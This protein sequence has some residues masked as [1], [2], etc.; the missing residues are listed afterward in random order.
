MDAKRVLRRASSARVLCLLGLALSLPPPWPA[1][2]DL[3]TQLTFDGTLEDSGPGGNDGTFFGAGGPV[4]VLGADGTAGGALSLDGADDFVRLTN[5]TALPIHQNPQFSLAVWVQGLGTQNDRRVF[6]E[7]SSTNATPLWTLGTQSQGTASTLDSYVRSSAGTP[8]NHDQSVGA[9][10]DGIWHHLAWVDNN[11]DVT[12]YIDGVVDAANFD[13]PRPPATGFDT[14]TI[15]SVVRDSH[16]TPQCC[17]YAGAVDDLRL[18]DHVLSQVEIEAI[19]SGEGECPG[20]GSPDFA[21]TRLGSVA[22]EGPIDGEPG[23]PG[24]YRFTALG[25]V[26]DTGDTILYAFEA[27]DGEGTVLARELLE[28]DSAEFTL[29]EGEWTVTARVDDA[30]LCD[31]AAGTATRSLA[32]AVTCPAA[33]DTTVAA[34]IIEGPN[35]TDGGGA[36]VNPP[37]TYRA[38]AV[39]PVDE[40]GGAVTLTFTAENGI[41]PPLVA[42]PIAGANSALF[43]LHPGEWTVSVTAD[44]NDQCDDTSPGATRSSAITVSAVSDQLVSRWRLDGNFLDS[45]P[46]GNDGVLVDPDGFGATFVDGFDANPAGAVLLDGVNDHVLAGHDAHLP[47]RANRAYSVALWVRGLTGQVD[48]RVFSESYSRAASDPPAAQDIDPLFNIGTH[49]TGADGSVDIYIRDDRGVVLVPHLRTAR[50]AFDGSWHHV[51]WVA[52]DGRGAVYIDAVRDQTSFNHQH[53]QLTLDTTSLG[54]V[55]RAESSFWFDGDLDDVRVYNYALS[56]AE[57]EAL[58]PEPLGC[59]DSGDPDFRDTICDTLEVEGPEGGGSNLTGVYTLTALDADDLSG[60]PVIYTFTATHPDGDHLQAGPQTVNTASIRIKKEGTWTFSVVVDDDLACRDRAAGATCTQVRE[61]SAPLRRLITRYRFDGNLLDSGAAGNHG[62]F[63]NA[64]AP[65]FVPDPEG[66]A[67]SALALDGMNDWVDPQIAGGLPVFADPSVIGYTVALWVRGMPQPDMRV[68]SEESSTDNTPLFTLGTA[69]GGVSGAFNVFIRPGPGHR[70]STGVAFDG[71]WHHVAWVDA[72]GEAV[73]YID[74][75]PD[76]ADFRYTKP[77][78][79]LDRATVGAVVRPARV[80]PECCLFT[81]ELDD[82]RVYNYAL[83]PEEVAIL[84]SGGEDTDLDAVADGLDNCPE[85][86]N[87]EQT[88]TDLDLAGDACDP[89][90]DGDGVADGVD[91]CP[92]VSNSAQTDSDGDGLGDACDAPSGVGPFKRGDCNQDGSNTGQVTDGVFLLNYLFQGGTVP[93]C[94]AACD[95]NGDGGVPGSPTDAVAYFNFNFQGGTPLADPLRECARSTR[96][97]DLRVGCLEP[98]ACMPP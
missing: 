33:G 55:A 74:G 82:V 65:V 28:D 22:A 30:P 89:D 86:P 94:L 64:Q 44:D 19:L 63:S 8:N 26:D 40:S 23:E 77:D 87:P 21:D 70:P 38:T 14:T 67:G 18:Y 5:A 79:P 32:V 92:L 20:V 52:E 90:D 81:G 50:M 84:A 73:L 60:D 68:Y 25:A 2:A 46:A 59:P 7:S 1:R 76:A 24:V 62:T 35:A 4:Y 43:T 42:G 49:S 80:P 37:G 83:S 39:A 47:I 93:P 29:G 45:Q 53:G 56:S 27:S 15:G 88:D 36:G 31:D 66:N 72:C 78:L 41:D 34:L 3:V 91:N 71:T 9:A 13:Y 17:F 85:V 16:T 54:A 11:G 58:V 10:F 95:M 6:S 61:V 98:R 57:I 97:E 96:P 12:L 75:V 69:Q 48:R 51:V